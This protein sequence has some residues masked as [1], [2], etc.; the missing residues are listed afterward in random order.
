MRKRIGKKQ[1]QKPE[2]YYQIYLIS[3]VS[4]GCHEILLQTPEALGLFQ[5]HRDFPELNS[6]RENFKTLIPIKPYQMEKK[7]WKHSKMETEDKTE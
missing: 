5:H 1:K 4:P 2:H 6:D 7:N 3:A